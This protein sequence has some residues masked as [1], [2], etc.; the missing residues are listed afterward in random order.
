MR[1]LIPSATIGDTKHN[2]HKNSFW[3]NFNN[4]NDKSNDNDSN[5]NTIHA[6][7]PNGTSETPHAISLDH[8]W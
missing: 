1:K 3:L 5:A 7:F 4:S 6:Q 2:S 8:T